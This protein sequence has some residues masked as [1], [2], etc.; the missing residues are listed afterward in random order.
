MNGK[1]DVLIQFC[2]NAAPFFN[3]GEAPPPF[4]NLG[5]APPPGFNL[6]EAPPPGG[7]RGCG[8][9]FFNL[10]EGSAAGLNGDKGGGF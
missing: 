3:L 6:G 10:G 2:R 1:M 5:E 4:F 7:A 8:R 9:P